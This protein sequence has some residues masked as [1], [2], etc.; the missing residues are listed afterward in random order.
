M[1]NNNNNTINNN[2]NNN[3]N[4]N[5]LSEAKSRHNIS[6]AKKFVGKKTS[7][8]CP[9]NLITKQICQQK[10]SSLAKKFIIFCQLFF[11]DKVIIINREGA[12]P[13]ILSESSTFFLLTCLVVANTISFIVEHQSYFSYTRMSVSSD[14][15][16][17]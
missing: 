8:L 7:S 10:I 3:N 2:N 13:K 12:R 14:T 16:V 11:S 15:T 6:S 17:V 9:R 4:N 5:T 1:I